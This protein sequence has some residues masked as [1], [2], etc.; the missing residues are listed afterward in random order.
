[1]RF[2]SHPRAIYLSPSGG[3]ESLIPGKQSPAWDFEWLIPRKDYKPK[4]D[5]VFRTCL[6]YKE[7]VIDEDI[8]REVR[9]VQRSWATRRSRI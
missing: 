3:G 4:Q 7:F 9:K 5:Y 8:I 1:M 2:N 6:I